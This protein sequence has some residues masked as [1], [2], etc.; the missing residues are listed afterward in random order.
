MWFDVS[1]QGNFQLMNFL[2][3]LGLHDQ[4][5]VTPCVNCK[6]SLYLKIQI[7]TIWTAR[8]LR[9]SHTSTKLLTTCNNFEF[10]TRGNTKKLD[11]ELHW[12]KATE[13]THHYPLVPITVR[14][15]HVKERSPRQ[16]L[17][18]SPFPSLFALP[19]TTHS[20]WGAD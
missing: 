14:T 4:I 7:S 10:L 16:G 18:L 20:D 5:L 17:S 1:P 15:G 8:S 3:L 12:H 13:F 2:F 11:S 19:Y 6:D 9:V